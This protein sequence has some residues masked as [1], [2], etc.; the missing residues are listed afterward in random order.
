MPCLRPDNPPG[1]RHPGTGHGASAHGQHTCR[2]KRR[3]VTTRTAPPPQF[4]GNPTPP[5]PINCL[6]HRTHAVPDLHAPPRAAGAASSCRLHTAAS[7]EVRGT[8]AIRLDEPEEGSASTGAAHPHP[9]QTDRAHPALSPTANMAATRL[10]LENPRAARW[11]VVRPLT[12]SER[13]SAVSR[14]LVSHMS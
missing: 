7:A 4:R 11:S 8:T 12:G 13:S 6:A 14:D 5:R 3:P 10:S 9:L 2:R 1:I